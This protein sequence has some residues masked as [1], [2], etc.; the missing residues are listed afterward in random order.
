MEVFR[1]S[2]PPDDKWGISHRPFSRVLQIAAREIVGV[3]W[4]PQARAYVGYRDGMELLLAL[5]QSPKYKIDPQNIHGLGRFNQKPIPPF[6][7]L[8]I[9][10]AGRRDYQ[11]KGVEFL[12][13]RRVAILADTM[14]LGKTV[15]ALTAARAT[16]L[17]R[18]LVVAPNSV[19]SVWWNTVDGGEIGKWL[20]DRIPNEARGIFFP[21]GIKATEKIPPGT[22]AVIIHYELLNAWLDRLLGWAPQIVVVDEAHVIYGADSQRAVAIRSLGAHASHVW[23]LTGTPMDGRPRDLFGMVEAISPGRFGGP[24]FFRSFGER[25]CGGHLVEVPA[26]GA[27]GE[28][29]SVW[30]FDGSSNEDELRTRL[31]RFVLRR[32]LEDVKLQL[33]PKVRQVVWLDVP[34]MARGADR[35]SPPTDKRAIQLALH[36]AADRKLPMAIAHVGELLAGGE[37]VVAFCWRREVAEAVLESWGGLGWM[38]HGGVSAMRRVKAL[39]EA[40]HAATAG[41][42]PGTGVLLAVTID[43]CGIGIDLSWAGVGVFVEANYQPRVLL[44]AE[45]RIARF[46]ATGPRSV[47][48]YLLGRGTIDERI[49]DIV[50]SKLDRFSAVFGA[51][52]DTEL[53]N[54]MV[55]TTED[56]IVAEIMRRE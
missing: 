47:L 36:R 2:G 50:V 35:E 55:A 20:I 31:G 41:F 32:T 39:G 38:V 3:G 54:E 12:L 37:K 46:G 5:L 34:G 25:Y 43:T 49:A 27:A 26:R 42:G 23:A 33:P 45:A 6:N 10:K 17:N 8:V 1:L 19:K 40:R 30:N 9:A 51:S 21:V 52:G 4:D 22:S 28:T 14:G 56:S 44:Q 24:E 53:G 48:Q 15:Q 18:V 11:V 16:G 7:Y 13:A 29:K